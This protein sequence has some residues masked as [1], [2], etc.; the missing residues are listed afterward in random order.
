MSS[1][2]HFSLQLPL[3]SIVHIQHLA[4]SLLDIP[5]IAEKLCYRLID[6]LS[7]LLFPQSNLYAQRT[8]APRTEHRI[9]GIGVLA[10]PTYLDSWLDLFLLAYPN[11]I[12][13]R[14]RF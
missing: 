12:S 14:H 8:T 3:P 9:L 5:R 4:H 10:F 11:S 1:S 13:P 7:V 2:A 6:H